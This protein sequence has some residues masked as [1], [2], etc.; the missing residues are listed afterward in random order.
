MSGKSLRI[1]VS[2]RLCSAREMRLLVPLPGRSALFK[3]GIVEQALLR[4]HIVQPDV[5]CPA[6]VG[7]RAVGSEYFRVL[8]YF[9]IV[10]RR[11]DSCHR[12]FPTTHYNGRIS[13]KSLAG[14]E[15]GLYIRRHT[16][17]LEPK[18]RQTLY[19]HQTF[20]VVRKVD[21]SNNLF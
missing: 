11:A 8:C 2:D 1:A 16:Q 21:N 3:S 15:Q 18:D 7:P 19:T 9:A 5:A 14:D 10:R 12:F 17:V 6:Q 4:Q 20:T 13:T